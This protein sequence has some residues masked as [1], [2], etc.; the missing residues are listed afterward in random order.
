MDLIPERP[1]AIREFDV[2]TG[3][4]H[5]ISAVTGENLE[6]LLKALARIL[7]GK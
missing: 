4:V 6:N 5:Y 7:F 1:F 2:S 3:E